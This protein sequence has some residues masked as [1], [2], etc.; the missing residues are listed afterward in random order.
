MQLARLSVLLLQ[1]RNNEKGWEYMEAP[2]SNFLEY[3]GNTVIFLL[4]ITLSIG[5]ISYVAGSSDISMQI[6]MEHK[7]VHLTEGSTERSEISKAEVYSEVQECEDISIRISGYELPSESVE[8]VKNY[9]LTAED[10]GLVK[11]QYKKTYI[12]DS[13]GII[14]G[15]IY[16]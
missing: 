16:Q 5:M 2:L 7:N 3:I 11:D 13:D 9:E 1:D 15:V 8:A 4:A 6:R 14:T 12:I 10:I